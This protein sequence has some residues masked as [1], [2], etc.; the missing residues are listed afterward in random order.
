MSPKWKIAIWVSCLS[1][2]SF[3]KVAV[4]PVQGV[5]TD[6]SFTDAFGALLANKYETISGKTTIPPLVSGKAISSDSSYIVA[7]Q[8]LGVEEFLEIT[9]VGLYISRKEKYE[10]QN[11]G[12]AS[13]TVKVIV[14]QRH[15]DDDDDDDD[16]GTDQDKLDNSKTIVTVVRKNS[17]GEKMYRT[18][19]TLLT[20]GDIEESAERIALSLFKQLPVKETRSLTN[21]TRREGMGHNKLFVEKLTGIRLGMAYPAA[22]DVDISPFVTVSFDMRLESEKFFLEFG[23]GGRIPNQAFNSDKRSYGGV[24]MEVGAAYFLTHSEIGVY[25]GGGINPF[26]TMFFDDGVIGVAPFASFGITFPRN[27]KTR[28]FTELRVAQNVMPIYT[29]TESWSYYNASYLPRTKSYPT[30]IG[31]NIGIGW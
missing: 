31:L 2:I 6:K 18:E 9:A 13:G 28:I 12:D 30:E 27:S 15:D 26:F 25:V 24:S 17:A 1:A 29:G 8:T 20:Y 23:A 5:N 4:F 21:I 19:M 22:G 3:A 11:S 10:V 14:T 16:D 7:A